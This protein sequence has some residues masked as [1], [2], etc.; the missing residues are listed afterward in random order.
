MADP[1]GAGDS[2]IFRQKWGPKG[3]KHAGTPPPPPPI[4]PKKKFWT[5]G[6]PH[7]L[8]VWIC[9]WRRNVVE[10]DLIRKDT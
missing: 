6:P 2:F 1:G 9:V 7:Y 4:P 5:T 3:R 10:F 8:K